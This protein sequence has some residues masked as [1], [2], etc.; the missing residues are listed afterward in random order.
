LYFDLFNFLLGRNHD[1]DKIE[2]VRSYLCALAGIHT[3]SLSNKNLT[4]KQQAVVFMSKLLRLTYQY[5]TKTGYFSDADVI[6]PPT[7]GEDV[8]W[9]RYL[10]TTGSSGAQVKPAEKMYDYWKTI[11]KR[12]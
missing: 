4:A 3:Q 1:Y 9:G 11:V 5:G 10:L 6:A 8:P 12:E 2:Q 7:G